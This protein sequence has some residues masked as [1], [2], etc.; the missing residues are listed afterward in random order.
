[1]TAKISS[2]EQI[3]LNLRYSLQ[4][5][6]RSRRGFMMLYADQHCRVCND[7]VKGN[8]MN[9]HIRR[10]HTDQD[11]TDS[12]DVAKVKPTRTSR[13]RSPHSPQKMTKK[14]VSGPSE[15]YVRN[16]VLCM[17]RRF[18]NVNL[19]SLSAYLKSHFSDIP[20]SSRRSRQL[21][22]LLPLTGMPW[23]ATMMLECHLQRRP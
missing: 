16:A 21:R 5:L 20:E 19:P 11:S 13:S 9:R 23:L 7:F 8:N 12:D 18:E 22:K 10:W 1:M 4:E 6:V 14:S 15:E 17:L 3:T 2:N